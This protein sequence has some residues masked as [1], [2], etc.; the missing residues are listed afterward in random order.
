MALIVNGERIEDSTIK[1]E[2]ERLRPDYEKAFNNM[3][4]Q[5]REAQLLDWSKENVIERILLK[6]ELKN[7]E[8]KIPKEQIESVL[9]GLK[10]EYKDQ[11]E[12]Y[13]DYFAQ[14]DE[15]VKK[16]IELIIKLRL[17][18]EEL[19]KDLNKPSQAAVQE[20]YQKNTEQFK[21]DEEVRV[22]H[23]VKYVDWQIDEAA[24]HTVIKQAQHELKKGAPFE[25]VADKYSDRTDQGGDLGY[26]SRGQLVEEFEDVV[27]NLGIGEVSDI[28][29]TRFGFHIAKVYDRKP[30]V[31][32]SLEEVK[33]KIVS[34]L[35]DQMQEKAIDDFI[36]QLRGKA[37]IE[38]I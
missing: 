1:Q 23:I 11:Q 5:E 4:A 3:P 31:I 9:A 34:E 19:R 30:A 13:K 36:D 33:S 8:P 17:K 14:N 15:E 10:K 6:Q 22:A 2:V 16:L 27:F 21:S 20:Y 37:K 25:F 7:I 32:P 28:F 38:E 35:K 29:R 24:A 12:F 26:V 18:F